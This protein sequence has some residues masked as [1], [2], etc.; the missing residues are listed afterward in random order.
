MPNNNGDNDDD[1]SDNPSL[2]DIE[3]DNARH[4][5]LRMSFFLNVCIFIHTDYFAFIY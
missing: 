3:D 2:L 5:R 1:C 4:R